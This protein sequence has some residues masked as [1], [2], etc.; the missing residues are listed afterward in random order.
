MSRVL[1]QSF[2]HGS[3]RHHLPGVPEQ[4]RQHHQPSLRAE[5]FLQAAEQGLIGLLLPVATTA[6]MFHRQGCDRELETPGEFMAGAH[7]SWMLTV[8][9]QDLITL[10]ERQ[11]PERQNASGGD[12]FAEGQSMGRDPADSGELAARAVDLFA[13]VRPDL[14]CEGSQFLDCLLYTS[15]AA[16][17]E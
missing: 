6:Q 1:L 13:D 4:M 7:H 9:D 10:F 16:D 12:V 15:D 2:G 11:S 8:A 3:N 17:E 5:V 14:C